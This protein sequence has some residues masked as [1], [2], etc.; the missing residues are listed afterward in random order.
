MI[1]LG[2]C[3][4]VRD[5]ALVASLGFDYLETPLGALAEMGSSMFQET[6]SMAADADISV[7]VFH[8]LLPATYR[9]VGHALTP[10]AE[11]DRFFA[12]A[13]ERASRFSA[14]LVIFGGGHARRR[15]DGF[16]AERAAAQLD[17]FLI[18]CCEA[19]ASYGIAVAIEPLNQTECNQINTVRQAVAWAKRLCLPNLTA[20]GD[21]YHMCLEAE[22]FDAIG[23]GGSWVGHLHIAEPSGRAYPHAGGFIDYPA[24]F[25]AL[26]SAGYAGRLSVE[27]HTNNF[28]DDAA[29][30]LSLLRNARHMAGGLS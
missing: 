23:A 24:L 30:A 9:V 8:G 18:R 15:P 5:I 22:P 1:R 21:I 4:P 11:V 13:F 14:K 10:D 20:M 7:E 12:T 17:A 2:V 28:L 19:A 16:P 6:A 26:N 27:A 25:S 29:T 3:R